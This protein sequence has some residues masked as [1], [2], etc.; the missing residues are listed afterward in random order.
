MKP[1]DW[2][3]KVPTTPKGETPETPNSIRAKKTPAKRKL[4]VEYN[5]LRCGA[6]VGEECVCLSSKDKLK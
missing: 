3:M 4:S 6:E 5:C 1:V 2:G